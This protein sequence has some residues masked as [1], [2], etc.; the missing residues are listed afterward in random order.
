VAR[1]TVLDGSRPAT[2]GVP[3]ERVADAN[4]APV[5]AGGRYVLYWMIG[6]RRTGWNFGLQ[7]AAERAR[8]FGR[9]LLVFEA[10]R[11][12]YPF[13]AA[14]F[15]RFVLDGM[16]DNAARFRAAG[17]TYY[18]YVEPEAGAGRGLLERLAAEA[19][20]VVT[21]DVPFFFLP[22]MVRAAARR[23]PVR[24][25]RVDG[26]GLLP[27]RRAD[28]AYDTARSF[29]ALLQRELPSRLH[30]LPAADPLAPGDRSRRASVPAD[31]RRRWP[32][33]A[34]E[35]L[36]GRAG[37]GRLPI[38]PAVP[39]AP[40]RGGPVAARAALGRFLERL[41]RYEAERNDPDRDATSGLSAYLHFGHLSAHEVFAAV[42]AA[43]RWNEGR[44]GR[45]AG[46]ARVGWWGMGPSA[47]AFLD[48]LVT[49]RE[50]ALNR[51]AF[52]EAAERWESL[53]A[54]ARATLERHAGDPRPHLYS[55]D[56]L[57]R[58]ATH[59][60]LWNAAQ[61]QLVRE[62]RLHNYLRMLWG[63]KILEWSATPREALA[64]MLRL[65]DRWALDGRDANSIAGVA[66]VLGRYDRP[67][68]PERPIFGTVRFM[69]STN[70]ARKLRVR[71]F[72]GR[73][74][75]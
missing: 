5:R 12:G 46:G 26:N 3:P 70:T 42:A 64:T 25:E 40:V 65:N 15:H 50:L 13:A 18:P 59:D 20:L 45:P 72:L 2:A 61:T 28:R 49:W 68:G 30:E 10:L 43:E 60:R 36:A 14:R 29:R 9:P 31:V 73:Y 62:G 75:R 63:K 22:R 1:A 32:V 39:Q 35:L 24:L 27:L 51:C 74:G 23:L 38:D 69:S 47:E 71:E 33:A 54:W 41:D 8:E 17:V 58:A 52:D 57:E 4:E 19:C 53:P 44:L 67:W 16:R 6:A 11:A 37:L 34:P 56:E 48:Q 66:W 55:P 7:R 21:D